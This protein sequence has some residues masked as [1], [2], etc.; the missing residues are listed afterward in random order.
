MDDLCAPFFGKV[1]SFEL[2]LRSLLS[3][4]ELMTEDGSSM[5]EEGGGDLETAADNGPTGEL[6]GEGVMRSIGEKVAPLPPP[7]LPLP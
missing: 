7:P 6:C 1:S 3:P 5:R 4:E 2:L